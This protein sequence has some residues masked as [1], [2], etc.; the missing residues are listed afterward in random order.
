MTIEELYNI[1]KESDLPR[2]IKYKDKIYKYY[3]I[4]GDYIDNNCND[5]IFYNIKDKLNDKVEI[6]SWK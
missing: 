5:F 4:A 2:I 1:E 3:E 6:I